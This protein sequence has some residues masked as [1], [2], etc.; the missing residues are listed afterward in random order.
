MDKRTI[1]FILIPI[2]WMSAIWGI[3]IMKESQLKN[4][5]EVIL[6]TVPVDPRDIFRGE[7]VTLRYD[8]STVE[9]VDYTASVTSKNR[10][11]VGDT[12]YVYISEN[13]R[14]SRDMRSGDMVTKQKPVGYDQL[15]IKGVVKDMS[16][17]IDDP[18]VQRLTIEYGIESYFV[19]EGTGRE[20]ES[21]AR[22][23]DLKIRIVVDKDGNATI[24][25]LEP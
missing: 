5:R 23:G 18:Y 14:L 13:G 4:G 21:R 17:D 10:I 7:Y 25:S 12:V 9:N 2:I 1:A 16:S 3:V 15:Y 19:P 24:K 8:I 6:Q 11:M 22:S 20:I